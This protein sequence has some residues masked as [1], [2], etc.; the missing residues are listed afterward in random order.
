MPPNAPPRNS[1][2]SDGVVTVPRNAPPK[3]PCEIKGYPAPEVDPSGNMRRPKS[4]E[5]RTADALEGILAQLKRIDD[6]LRAIVEV[7]RIWR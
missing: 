5:E 4:A 1:P 2:A 3:S 6:D 7:S